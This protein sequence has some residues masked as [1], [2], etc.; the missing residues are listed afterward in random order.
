MPIFLNPR[1]AMLLL[2][3]LPVLGGVTVH[4]QGASAFVMGA[5]AGAL[6]IVPPLFVMLWVLGLR[7]LP[8]LLKPLLRL[9]IIIG[10]SVLVIYL[11]G[12][13]IGTGWQLLGGGGLLWWARRKAGILSL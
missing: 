4:P 1:F 8:E 5:W 3:G 11:S 9:P 6:I 7:S 12:N 10:L 13:D 2:I